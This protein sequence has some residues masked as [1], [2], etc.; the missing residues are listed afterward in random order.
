[1]NQKIII[2]EDDHTNGTKTKG[3]LTINKAKHHEMTKDKAINLLFPTGGDHFVSAP[4][5]DFKTHI[6]FCSKE[7]QMHIKSP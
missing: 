4:S 6:K 5:N 1:M 2:R 7:L 3:N